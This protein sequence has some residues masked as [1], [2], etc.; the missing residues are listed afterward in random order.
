MTQHVFMLKIVSIVFIVSPWHDQMN[1]IGMQTSTDFNLIC[2]HHNLRL[3]FYGCFSCTLRII[4]EVLSHELAMCRLVMHL[5]FVQGECCH[6]SR[7]YGLFQSRIMWAYQEWLTASLS[8]QIAEV[9]SVDSFC[10]NDKLHW[11]YNWPRNI[12]CEG[13]IVWT[14]LRWGEVIKETFLLRGHSSP[15]TFTVT[16]TQL[17][18]KGGLNVQCCIRSD[19]WIA[20]PSHSILCSTWYLIWILMV[21][22]CIMLV[23]SLWGFVCQPNVIPGEFVMWL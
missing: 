5:D 23:L 2:Q 19:V 8:L 1:I 3:L 21:S 6:I 17:D 11:A 9:K 13:E 7:K 12:H 18:K 4:W 16:L 14:L 20:C 15:E 10:F 22:G